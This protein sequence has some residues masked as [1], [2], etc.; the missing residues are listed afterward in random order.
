MTKTKLTIVSGED[1]KGIY[2]DGKL[3]SEGHSLNIREILENLGY[4][5]DDFDVNQEWLENEGLP[6]DLKKVKKI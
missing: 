2:A 3:L 1:W 4:D 5:V 6:K